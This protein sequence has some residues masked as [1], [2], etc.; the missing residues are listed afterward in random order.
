MRFVLIALLSVAFFSPSVR[1]DESISLKAIRQTVATAFSQTQLSLDLL[2]WVQEDRAQN[3]VRAEFVR[4]SLEWVRVSEALVLMRGVTRI[5]SDSAGVVEYLGQI[6]PL[7]KDPASGK[8]QVEILTAI[9]T[10]ASTPI[11]VQTDS[12]TT[13]FRIEF[14]SRDELSSIAVDSSCSPYSVNA[15]FTNPKA[16]KIYSIGCRD[17]HDFEEDKRRPIVEV[18]I[19]MGAR[20][21]GVRVDGQAVQLQ[22]GILRFRINSDTQSVLIQDPEAGDFE[23]TSQISPRYHYLN[24]GFGLGPY[25]QVIESPNQSFEGTV[26]LATIYGSY[27][28]TESSRMVFFSATSVRSFFFTDNGFYYNSESFRILD[29]RVSINVM[30]GLNVVGYGLSDATRFRLG[31]PQGVE[32]IFR[33][34]FQKNANAQAGAFIYPS[35][36]DKAY[37][38]VWFRYGKRGIFGELNYIAVRDQF[39]SIPVYSKSVGLSFGFPLARFF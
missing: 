12:K 35:I 28:V 34:A 4:G 21:P 22:D 30:L 7:R 24:L 37:Y 9:R 6:H 38:N 17:V 33:D 39:G 8:Y 20:S 26:A 31:F 32:F 25:R 1:A 36:N 23:I 19:D 13:V 27:F 2:Q 29:R 14:I 3:G 15:K 18:E 10:D 5:V 16:P 11:K